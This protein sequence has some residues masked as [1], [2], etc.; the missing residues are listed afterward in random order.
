MLAYENMGQRTLAVESDA[1]PYA[2]DFVEFRGR[3]WSVRG[4]R[5]QGK[6]PMVV[7]QMTF[8]EPLKISARLTLADTIPSK[9]TGGG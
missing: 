2:G 3:W 7:L 5:M 9:G 8:N 6:T 4:V 1:V